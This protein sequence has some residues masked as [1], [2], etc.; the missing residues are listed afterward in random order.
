M[1]IEKTIAIAMPV[2]PCW[3]VSFS[4]STVDIFF[5]KGEKKKVKVK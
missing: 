4:G 5:L 3:F 1:R 2:L